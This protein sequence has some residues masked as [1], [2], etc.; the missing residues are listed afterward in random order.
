MMQR[1]NAIFGHIDGF[2]VMLKKKINQRMWFTLLSHHAA[3]VDIR[4]PGI[5]LGG[6]ESSCC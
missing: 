6:D 2:Q 3:I 5:V 4:P 1:T